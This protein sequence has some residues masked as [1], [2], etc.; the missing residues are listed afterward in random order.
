M[1][2]AWAQTAPQPTAPSASITL[3]V[4]LQDAPRRILHAVETIPV[5]PGPTTLVFPK[6]IPGEHSPSGP[7]DNQAGFILTTNAGERVKCARDSLDMFTYH[8][9]VPAGATSLTAKMDFLA[10]AAAEGF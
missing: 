7:I 6:W 1:F 10:P 8:L 5:G 4:D 2:P 9:T 3:A